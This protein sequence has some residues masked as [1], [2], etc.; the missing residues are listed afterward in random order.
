[1]ILGEN[2]VKLKESLFTKTIKFLFYTF[3]KT[4][5]LCLFLNIIEK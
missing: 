1:M 5:V 3:G 4:D 2:E